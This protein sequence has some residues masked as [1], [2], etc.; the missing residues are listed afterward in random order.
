[1]SQILFKTFARQQ[2]RNSHTDA[3]KKENTKSD[4]DV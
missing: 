4:G 2:I 3:K 1:M